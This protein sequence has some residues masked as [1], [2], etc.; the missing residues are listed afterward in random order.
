MRNTGCWPDRRF[1]GVSYENFLIF[2]RKFSVALLALFVTLLAAPAA[3]FPTC[4]VGFEPTWR[5]ELPAAQRAVLLQ[6]MAMPPVAA[7]LGDAPADDEN[8]PVH[9]RVKR[10]LKGDGRVKPGGVMRLVSRVEKEE[11]M[12][13]DWS[14]IERK[15]K[16][17]FQKAPDDGTSP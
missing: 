1:R 10:V 7:D 14:V 6:P 17:F 9:L 11:A 3:A 8:P 12:A 15:A 16:S 5:E 13:K 4:G 2:V